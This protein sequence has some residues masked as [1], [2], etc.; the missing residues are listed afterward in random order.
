MRQKIISIFYALLAACFYAVNMPVSKTLLQTVPPTM[1]AAF[2]YLGA[3]LG[4]GGMYL[5]RKDKKQEENL[6]KK[7]LPYTVGMIAL[8]IF[9]P[10]ALMFGLARTTSANASLLNNFEIVATSVIALVVFKEAVSKRL[11]IAI[12][13][14]TLSSALLSFED[15]SSLRFSYGSLLV[16]LAAVCWGLE[17][18]CTRKIASKNTYEIVTLKGVGSGLGSL[19][20]AL[21]LG[22]KIPGLT[23]IALA[24]LLGFVAYGLSIFFYIKAQNVLGAAKTSAYYAVAPFIGAFLSFVFLREALS[25]SYALA[26]LLMVAGT[27]LIAADTLLTSHAH[28]HTH[29]IVHTHDGVTHTHVITHS[30]PHSHLR[31]EGEHT[32]HHAIDKIAP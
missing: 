24:L 32:H 16:L 9:A 23:Y 22:E 26:L 10:I 14:V 28:L 31:E 19:V 7:D 29:T 2:L 8:D 27:I 17:N 20:V 15:I 6:T 12:F 4:V 30:H 3:G 18:N 5:L 1:L 13:L 21:V 25:P 11:W